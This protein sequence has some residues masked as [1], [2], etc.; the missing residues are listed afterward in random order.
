MWD[1]WSFFKLLDLD[2]GNS[3]KITAL[4]I[5][6]RSKPMQKEQK[7]FNVFQ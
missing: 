4:S 2:R 5:V 7:Y 6:A 1:A 3:A